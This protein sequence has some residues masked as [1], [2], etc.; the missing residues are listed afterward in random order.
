VAP[1]W[2]AEPAAGAGG[3]DHRG[4]EAADGFALAGGGALISTGQVTRVTRDLDFFGLTAGAVD[5]LT[6]IA[7]HALRDAGLRVE[8]VVES[9]GFTRLLVEDE[10][11]RTELDLAADARLFP[12]EQGPGYAV[13]SAEEL[14]VDKVLAIFGRAEARDFADLMALEKQFV[15]INF[16]SWPPRRIADSASACSHR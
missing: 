3:E 5:K 4:L 7:E 15:S 16:S 8:R 14:A 1:N 6:P 10:S 13:L 9:P 11:D 2:R 12:V